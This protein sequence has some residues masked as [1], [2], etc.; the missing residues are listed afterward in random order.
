M[1]S[2]YFQLVKSGSASSSIV[3]VLAL[4][5]AIW[6]IKYYNVHRSITGALTYLYNYQTWQLKTLEAKGIRSAYISNYW[7]AWKWSGERWCLSWSHHLLFFILE[8][9]LNSPRWQNVLCSE[10]Y[11]NC[12]KPIEMDEVHCIKKW[13]LVASMLPKSVETIN[14]QTQQTSSHNGLWNSLKLKHN[15][16][17]WLQI[18]LVLYMYVHVLYYIYRQY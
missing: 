9:L 5:T 3:V 14:K 13:H 6:S 2:T 17:A 11:R 4:F 16:Y 7:W 15:E 18:S 1:P 10:L 12:L 8:L